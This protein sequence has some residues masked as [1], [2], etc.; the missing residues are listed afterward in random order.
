MNR[1]KKSLL[2]NSGLSYE[3]IISEVYST[4]NGDCLR[5]FISWFSNLNFNKC[6]VMPLHLAYRL[7]NFCITFFSNSKALSGAPMK[8][9]TEVLNFTFK[10]KAMK[11]FKE[12]DS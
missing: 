1:N 12:R 10:T 5:T 4:K 8:G 3:V 2:G 11:N 9:A 6:V 7:P